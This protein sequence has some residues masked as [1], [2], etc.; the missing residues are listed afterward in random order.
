MASTERRHGTQQKV[1]ITIIIIVIIA[2]RL[3]EV[4]GFEHGPPLNTTRI[5]E[6]RSWLEKV[7]RQ[8]LKAPV[9]RCICSCGKASE[10]TRVDEAPQIIKSAN[11]LCCKSWTFIISSGRGVV[12]GSGPQALP[13]NTRPHAT[14]RS[15]ET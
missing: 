13:R 4:D 14:I 5:A 2:V 1:I 8:P 15:N 10:K 9:K 11:S 12:T 7:L 6:V 3:Q